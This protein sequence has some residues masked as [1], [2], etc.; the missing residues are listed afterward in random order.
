MFGCLT[1]ESAFPGHNP[2]FTRRR[3][4]P[5]RQL[6]PGCFCPATVI[7]RSKDE[8]LPSNNR[9]NRI[10]FIL[11]FTAFAA[12]TDRV[13]ALSE[14]LPAPRIFFPRGYSTNRAE[15]IQA[16]LRST[17]FKYLGGMTSYWPPEWS[18]TLVY[19]GDQQGLNAF[20]ENLNKI[21]ALTVR[22]TLSPN[23]SK[24]TGSALPAGS[25][26]VKYSHTAPDTITVRVN[27]AAESLGRDRF[28][29]KLPK[30]KQ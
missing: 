25:W 6:H 10:I 13:L 5:V 19:A 12:S 7:F 21:S 16:V 15:Q 11:V 9:M 18:T 23:L 20:L 2:Q 14:E 17:Q 29:V 26:W 28:E 1:L 8:S 3:F 30:P 24:E 4:L 22:V 27:L